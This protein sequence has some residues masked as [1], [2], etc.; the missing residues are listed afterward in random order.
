MLF[1]HTWAY[2]GIFKAKPTLILARAQEGALG[3][4]G[5]PEGGELQKPTGIQQDYCD[6]TGMEHGPGNR[7]LLLQAGDGVPLCSSVDQ[8]QCPKVK[9]SI[10]THV[11]VRVSSADRGLQGEVR[12]GVPRWTH[13]PALCQWLTCGHWQGVCALLRGMCEESPRT[14]GRPRLGVVPLKRWDQP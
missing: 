14:P 8:S 5:L 4:V 10:S 1:G 9:M 11:Q 12:P 3:G 13:V 6:K 7:F 2:L